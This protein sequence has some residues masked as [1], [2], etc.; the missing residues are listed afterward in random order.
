MVAPLVVVANVTMSA[1]FCAADVATA[2]AAAGGA[3]PGPPI[4]SVPPP[5][6][7]SKAPDNASARSIRFPAFISVSI[8]G[9]NS[10][11]PQIIRPRGAAA[12]S[13]ALHLNTA[14]FGPSIEAATWDLPFN[15]ADQI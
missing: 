8:I 3:G 12:S 7:H 14:S 2:G 13:A 11:P 15:C 9:F 6:P 5:Q 4:T 1:P 10:C